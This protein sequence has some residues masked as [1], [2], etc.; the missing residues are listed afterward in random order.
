ME[1]V[2]KWFVSLRKT[3]YY[4]V[5][6]N[7]RKTMQQKLDSFVKTDPCFMKVNVTFT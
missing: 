4:I 5:L 7:D 3:N 2:Q 1:E 6:Y